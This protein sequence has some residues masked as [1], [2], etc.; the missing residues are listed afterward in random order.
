MSI[1]DRMGSGTALLRRVLAPRPWVRW[2][3]LIVTALVFLTAVV[4]HRRQ[5]GAA[6]SSWGDT[7]TVWV[8]EHG[9]A[10]GDPIRAAPSDRPVAV[11]PD[12]PVTHDPSGVVARQTIGAGEIVTLVDVAPNGAPADLIP[13]G[14]LA[15]PVVE[16]S[17]SWASV[18][19][20]V[21]V[22]AGG[23]I[24]SD[25]GLIVAD[26]DGAPLVAVPAE[27]A[28]RVAL[29]NESGVTLLRTP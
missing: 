5:L 10:A 1:I 18:G 15:V 22:T 20:R 24:V 28:P 6:R 13:P 11:L 29:A 3:V 27:V 2:I 17:P 9:V 14:W 21:V 26:V 7:R 4:E 23:A 25:D 8:T 12:D 19:E 16:A